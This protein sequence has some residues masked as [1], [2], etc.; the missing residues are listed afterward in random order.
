MVRRIVRRLNRY[1]RVS[2]W[3]LIPFQPIL[4]FFVWGAAI[5]LAIN[6]GLPPPFDDTI[7]RGF[8]EVWLTLGITGPP[9]TLLAWWM[10]TKCSGRCTFLGM[11]LRLSSDIQVGTVLLSY[12]LVNV[13]DKAAGEG[14]IFSRYV[15]GAA[16]L[17]TLCLVIRD[18]WVLILTE[19]MATRIRRGDC[20]PNG[21]GCG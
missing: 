11:W 7:A 19:V 5:R 18:M 8:Y 14:K 20:G 12:H 1:F 2:A 3:S 10:I 13:A 9:L 15:V 21:E 6:D 4:Y 16:M 17:F